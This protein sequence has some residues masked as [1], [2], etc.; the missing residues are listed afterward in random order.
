[1]QTCPAIDAGVNLT[2]MCPLPCVPEAF[3]GR[4]LYRYV[5]TP[6]LSRVYWLRPE[7]VVEVTFSTWTADGLI[8]QAPYQRQREDKPVSDVVRSI[9]HA[10]ART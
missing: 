6:E 9:P 2:Q 4:R 8:R 1:M 10:S 5:S 7:V 3:A